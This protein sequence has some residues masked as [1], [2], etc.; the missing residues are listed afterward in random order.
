MMGTKLTEFEN[1][2]VPKINQ[3]LENELRQTLTRKR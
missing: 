1:L 3:V 2:W